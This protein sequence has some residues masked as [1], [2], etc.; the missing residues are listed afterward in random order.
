MIESSLQLGVHEFLPE[1]VDLSSLIIRFQ[2][3][4]L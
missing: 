3:H 2:N 4:N 1:S